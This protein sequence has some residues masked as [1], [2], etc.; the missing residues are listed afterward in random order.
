MEKDL[1]SQ[2]LLL[3]GS[4]PER[5]KCIYSVVFSL[6]MYCDFNENEIMN[7]LWTS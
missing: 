1:L 7:L 2:D 4:L 5:Y 6:L 3:T